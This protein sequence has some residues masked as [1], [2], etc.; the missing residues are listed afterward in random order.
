ML[1]AQEIKKAGLEWPHVAKRRAGRL[2]KA[3]LWVGAL[4][5]EIQNNRP[6]ADLTRLPPAWWSSD[7]LLRRTE[8]DVVIDLQ[9]VPGV[10]MADDEEGPAETTEPSKKRRQRHVVGGDAMSLRRA[11]PCW[12]TA[13][14][15]RFTQSFVPTAWGGRHVCCANP[16]LVVLYSIVFVCIVALSVRL[17]TG[18][19]HSDAGFGSTLSIVRL[20]C[21]FWTHF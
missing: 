11:H 20:V 13:E 9:I 6:V 16:G 1:E 8:G 14:G 12:S 10:P 21:S 17:H 5:R 7:Q 19:A 3:A 15:L 18:P 4:C 2:G